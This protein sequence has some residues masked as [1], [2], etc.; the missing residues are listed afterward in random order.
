MKKITI[1][2]SFVPCLLMA[3]LDTIRITEDNFGART[4]K[5]NAA[6]KA[7]N[8]LTSVDTSTYAISAGSADSSGYADTTGYALSSDS[9][10]YSDTTGYALSSN[11]TETLVKSYAVDTIE[12]TTLDSIKTIKLIIG[13][14]STTFIYNDTLI[15]KQYVD[16]NFIND[17]P[18]DGNQYARQNSAWAIVSGGGG[19][20]EVDTSGTPAADQVSF[21]TTPKKIGG[22]NNLK[23]EG[24]SV[25]NV[26]GDVTLDSLLTV[27]SN[28]TFSVNSI[29]SIIG[30]NNTATKNTVV[31]KSGLYPNLLGQNNYSEGPFNVYIGT[32]GFVDAII[33]AGTG[34]TNIIT[35][36]DS[37]G[38][39]NQMDVGRRRYPVYQI[40]VDNENVLGTNLPFVIVNDTL[41]SEFN[42]Y[43]IGDISYFFPDSVTYAATGGD[44]Y[45]GQS[46]PS[47]LPFAMH[48]FLMVRG[49]EEIERGKYRI[50]DTEYKVDTGTK[51]WF[52]TDDDLLPFDTIRYVLSSY[53]PTIRGGGNSQSAFGLGG[54]T[55]GYGS[56]TTGMQ[57][58]SW[59]NGTFTGGQNC[60]ADT[61]YSAAGG[62]YSYSRGLYSLIWSDRGVINK[63]ADYSVNFGSMGIN[64]AQYTGVFNK[65]GIASGAASNSFN[66]STISSGENSNAFNQNTISS[67]LASNSFGI[68]SEAKRE[69]QIAH[70]GGK[71][72]EAGDNQKSRTIETRSFSGAG[73]WPFEVITFDPNKV[74]NGDI[75]LKGVRTNSADNI[76]ESTVYEY[77]YAVETGDSVTLSVST[78]SDYIYVGADWANNTTLIFNKPSGATLPSPLNNF[79]LYYVVNTKTDSIQ[80]STSQGGGAVDLTTSGSGNN[81]FMQFKL[82][83]DKADTD[84]LLY[85]TFGDGG[86]GTTTGVR[87]NIQTNYISNYRL[88][89]RLDQ[90]AGYDI[91]W[92]LINEFS[93][94]AK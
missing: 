37:Y 9:A 78:S 49:G 80:V 60:I 51:I 5:Q 29:G 13:D 25:L 70:G 89:I 50:I 54:S 10:S 17:A 57:P 19:T 24:D 86:N 41:F 64:N 59:G 44:F 71:I 61:T 83:Y 72:N 74:Y 15:N 65:Y 55:Y 45:D 48:S 34:N 39:G 38:G 2:L 92:Q 20:G 87:T 94:L 8:D 85:R 67:G 30:D 46:Y 28:N 82:A 18:S 47:F 14:S 90:I 58:R 27:G 69:N 62:Y 35:A 76:T 26:G 16:D 33:G 91:R 3:Q 79:N 56:V 52:N 21:F 32:N 4:I 11:I 77:E 1:I 43:F 42:P 88:V 53:A 68:D 66:D 81:A 7:L 36:N 22:S 73:W 12:T 6:I 23:W 84:A 93:E 40:G 63:G 75:Y 31:G